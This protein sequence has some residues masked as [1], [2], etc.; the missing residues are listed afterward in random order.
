MTLLHLAVVVVIFILVVIAI[1]YF[2]PR[3][4]NPSSGPPPGRPLVNCM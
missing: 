3:F 4:K 2:G 1:R